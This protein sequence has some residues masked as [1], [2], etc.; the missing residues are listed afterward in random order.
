MASS[1]G[2]ASRQM[3]IAFEDAP[4]W[5]SRG[6]EAALLREAGRPVRLTLTENRSVLLS[7]RLSFFLSFRLSFRATRD[8]GRGT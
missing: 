1:N 8:A 4:L 3:S 6:L 5:D 2:S 7:F